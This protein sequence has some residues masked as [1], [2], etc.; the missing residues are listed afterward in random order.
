MSAGSYQSVAAILICKND[1]VAVILKKIAIEHALSPQL[2]APHQ[3][4]RARTLNPVGGL[5]CLTAD[6]RL[7]VRWADAH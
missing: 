4:R 2:L 5:G 3:I 6:D 7:G 1:F